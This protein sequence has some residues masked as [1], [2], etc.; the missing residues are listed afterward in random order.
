MRG[1]LLKLMNLR[2]GLCRRLWQ[3]GDRAAIDAKPT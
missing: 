2:L 3:I 1:K